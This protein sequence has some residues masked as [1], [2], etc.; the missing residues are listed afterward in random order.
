MPHNDAQMGDTHP[1]VQTAR[2]YLTDAR[3]LLELSQRADAFYQGMLVLHEFIRIENA[4]GSYSS[5]YLF[6]T[7]DS[8]RIGRRYLIFRSG[9]K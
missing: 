5:E 4:W 7:T 3:R 8:T 1:Q 6:G 2:R 9:I